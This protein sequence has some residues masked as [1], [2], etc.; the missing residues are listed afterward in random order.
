MSNQNIVIVG[1]G[2]AGVAIA[3]ELSA[4]L[5]KTGPQYNLILVT[6]R[7]CY[8][9]V[10]ASLR[11]AVSED[12]LEDTALIPYESVFV[13]GNG[14]VKIGN[15]VSIER[16]S[17][18]SGGHVALEGDENLSF[19]YLVVA[20]GS[21]WEGPIATVPD[22][23]QGFLK[24]IYQ[25]RKKFHDAKNIVIAGGGSV[26]LELSGELRDVYPDKKITIV[27]AGSLP[28]NDVYPDRF[29]KDIERRWH[30]R[31][32][33]FIFND[34]VEHFPD[35]TSGSIKTTNGKIIEADIVV[36]ARGGKPNTSLL[37]SLGDDVFDAQGYVKIAP[38]LQLPSY[39]DIFAAGDI[40]A[41]KEQKTLAKV[42][43]H[44][45][46]VA[47]NIISLVNGQQPKKTYA[48]TFEGLFVTNG[49]NKGAGYVSVL[50]GLTFGDTVV[51]MVKGKTLFIPMQRKAMGLSA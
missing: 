34:R 15:V 4:N 48:G 25:W 18:S 32:I 2:G 1:G 23:K 21:L 44:A 31:G 14:K 45:A 13:N 40:I 39:P 42:P 50:W 6:N 43:G 17:G 28:L 26:G 8:V 27:Q 19:R 38:T 41:F 33:D 3:R 46:V 11:M 51:P 22:G 5:P 35:Q 9:H 29:R 16:E 12:N 49:K 47:A 7:E 24:L 36:P 30:K 10:L 20:T 37:R